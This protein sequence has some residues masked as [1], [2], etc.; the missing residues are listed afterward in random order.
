MVDAIQSKPSPYS[1]DDQKRQFNTDRVAVGPAMREF[2]T[3]FNNATPTLLWV[4]SLDELIC[5]S[6]LR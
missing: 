6:G 4:T 1:I 3:L 2:D 5:T